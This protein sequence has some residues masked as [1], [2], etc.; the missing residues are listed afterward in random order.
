[1]SINQD[2][3][4]LK[5]RLNSREHREAFVSASVDQTIPFQIRALRL[6]KERIWTQEELARRAGMKQE[7]ISACENPSYGKFNIRT[8][9]Q[10]AAAFDVGLIVRFAPFSELTEWEINM[11]PESLEVPSFE[12]EDYFKDKL[13]TDFGS[14]ILNQ[15]NSYGASQQNKQSKD[16]FLHRVGR[17]CVIKKLD[18]YRQEPKHGLN[19][20]NPIERP[21]SEGHNETVVG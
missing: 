12:K 9:K 19:K 21:I 15:Y 14:G 10:L 8:L 20:E 18:D 6:S 13:D 16:K 2:R 7:R 17:P 1:M 11:S 4:A 5:K 3:E